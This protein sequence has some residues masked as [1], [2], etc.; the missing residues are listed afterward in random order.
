VSAY[1]TIAYDHD[2]EMEEAHMGEEG[3]NDGRSGSACY[4]ESVK[5]HFVK[6]RGFRLVAGWRKFRVDVENARLYNHSWMYY[7]SSG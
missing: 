6:E 2:T 7:S 5:W 3:R 1:P 4:G